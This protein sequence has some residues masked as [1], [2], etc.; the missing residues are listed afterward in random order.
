[1]WEFSKQT[2]FQSFSA[3]NFDFYLFTISGRTEVEETFVV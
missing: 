3:D 2:S 1:M